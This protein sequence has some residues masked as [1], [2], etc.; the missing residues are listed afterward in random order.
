MK[1]HIACLLLF[2]AIL[3]FSGCRSSNYKTAISSLSDGNYSNA[4]ELFNNLG[5]YKDSKTQLSVALQKEANHLEASQDYSN[6]VELLEKYNSVVEYSEETKQLFD[7][8]KAMTIISSDYTEEGLN[9]AIRIFYKYKDYKDCKEQLTS[10]IKKQADYYDSCKDYS[11][12]L[13]LLTQYKSI[14]N[15]EKNINYLSDYSKALNMISNRGNISKAIDILKQLPSNYKDSSRIIE[16]YNNLV[17]NAFIGEYDY[18]DGSG[19][20][21]VRVLLS[22]YLDLNKDKNALQLTAQRTTYW[23]DGTVYEQSTFVI[24]ESATQ[25]DYLISPGRIISLD[26]YSWVLSEDGKWIVESDR[27]H[28]ESYVFEKSYY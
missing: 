22:F 7:Y 5:D 18:S 27:A 25:F 4:I 1:K 10:A 17:N 24:D 28:G 6:I 14:I 8:S 13:T 3:S 11:K 15:D 20:Y 23:N 21:Y 2:F 16:S 12:E 9:E 26:A 19:I